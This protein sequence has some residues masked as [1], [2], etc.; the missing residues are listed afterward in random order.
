MALEFNL[1]R[2]DDVFKSY[3]MVTGY[4]VAIFDEDGIEIISY[5][6]QVCGLCK[7]LRS[8]D[9]VYEKCRR[10]ELCGFAKAKQLKSTYLYECEMGI[11][12]AVSPLLQGDEIIGYI[13]TGQLV[14]GDNKARVIQK[15]TPYFENRNA[16]FELVETA[17]ILNRDKLKAGAVLMSVCA[18]YLCLTKDLKRRQKHIFMVIK[19]YIEKNLVKK[20]TIEELCKE[21]GISRTSLY[22]LFGEMEGGGVLESVNQMRLEKAKTLIAKTTMSITQI[23]EAVGISDSNYFTRAFKK[24]YQMTPL[25]YRK[26]VKGYPS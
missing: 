3:H 16:L 20:I 6:K 12:E 21:F 7:V 19:E 26:S 11:Y 13:M 2:L 15:C 1:N 8:Y 25:L 14:D 9:E 22:K 18:E 10:T 24:S 4:R 5:P 17:E 23:S